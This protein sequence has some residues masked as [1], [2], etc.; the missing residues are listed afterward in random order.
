V[1]NILNNP[2][3][4]DPGYLY[5]MGYRGDYA[6]GAMWPTSSGRLEIP[7]GAP[8]GN[9]GGGAVTQSAYFTRGSIPLG[10]WEDPSLTAM[11][12]SAAA[13]GGGTS[14][15]EAQKIFSAALSSETGLRG[16]TGIWH[17]YTPQER[18]QIADAIAEYNQKYAEFI[19]GEGITPQEGGRVARGTPPRSGQ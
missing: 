10:Y 8:L 19:S 1:D 11:E 18:A 16:N 4:T 5:S 15:A 2:S 12:R 7:G 9:L 13:S 14:P 3:N 6:G 17:Q